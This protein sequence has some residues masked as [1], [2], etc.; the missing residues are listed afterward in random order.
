ML[1]RFFSFGG[2]MTSQQELQMKAT[3]YSKKLWGKRYP[4]KVVIMD[5][6]K[7]LGYFA[8]WGQTN[9]EIRIDQKVL[10]IDYLADNVLVHE[11]CHWWCFINKKPWMD[12]SKNFKSEL[13]KIKNY[14]N[15]IYNVD[16]T[17]QP[18]DGLIQLVREFERRKK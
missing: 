2:G 10:D 3:F 13:A 7:A 1:Y 12:H 8:K 11:L 14:E 9:Y 16:N 18:T 5:S 4:K 17:Y 6:D 15:D